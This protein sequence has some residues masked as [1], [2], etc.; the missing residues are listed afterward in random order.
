MIDRHLKLRARDEISP[1]L[2]D[3]GVITSRNRSVDIADWEQLVKIAEFDPAYL[4]L[5]PSSR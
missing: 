1:E 5:E 3:D 4:Y 2:R